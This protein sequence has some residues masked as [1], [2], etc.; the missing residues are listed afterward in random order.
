[1]SN[2]SKNKGTRAETLAKELLRKYTKLQWERTPLSGALDLKHGLK[3]DLYVPNEHNLYAV[4]VKH[5]EDDHLTSQILT[6]KNPQLI[7][8]WEQ[9]VRQGI[10]VGKKPLLIF[11]HNRSKMFVAFQDLPTA[12]YRKLYLEIMDYVLYIAVLEDWL[13]YE[14]PKFIK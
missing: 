6:S 8:W 4:E 9:A 7:Q 1:M 5:Y 10:Q 3:S 14:K 2:P 11:K 13:I 12:D